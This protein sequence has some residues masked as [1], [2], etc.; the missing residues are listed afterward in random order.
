[1]KYEMIS[2]EDVELFRYADDPQ[3]ALTILKEGLTRYYLER[4]APLPEEEQKVPAIAKSRIEGSP[5]RQ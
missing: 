1:V 5:T 2:P 3:T 4:E